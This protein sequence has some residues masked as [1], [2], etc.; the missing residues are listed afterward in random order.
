MLPHRTLIVCSLAVL[1]FGCA[2][3]QPPARPSSSTTAESH[4]PGAT[5]ESINEHFDALLF[6]FAEND[7]GRTWTTLE[8]QRIGQGFADVSAHHQR[9]TGRSLPEALYNAGLAFQR[10]GADAEAKQSFSRAGGFHAA[11]TE[12]VA[13][14]H[15]A[16]PDRDRSIGR[17]RRLVSDSKFQDPRALVLLA[18]LELQR[19]RA[20]PDGASERE[21]ARAN[22]QRALAIDDGYLPALNQ[23]A[24]YYLDLARAHASGHEQPFEAATR[25]SRPRPEQ[26]K[27]SRRHLELASFVVERALTHDADYAP[28][29]NTGGVIQVELENYTAAS[30]AFSRAR[31]L[32]PSFLDAHLNYAALNLRFRGFTEAE[33]G[34]RAALALEPKSYEAHLGLALALRGQL[35]GFN[36][37]RRVQREAEIERELAQAAEIA[38]SRPEVDFNRALFTL[39]RVRHLTGLENTRALEQARAAFERFVDKAGAEPHYAQDVVKAR[40]HLTDLQDAAPFMHEGSGR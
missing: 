30:R 32:D 6:R 13:I 1:A 33:H 11:R 12:L 40:E 21:L 20:L 27:L 3:P 4:R 18:A 25:L 19:A 16:L 37:R 38:P 28:V 7:R 2:R 9:R 22:L 5:D 35:P 23:L 17:L 26:Q 34:Y 36:P 10:C 39:T 29:H 24:I 15:R 14:E 8:C 31:Q